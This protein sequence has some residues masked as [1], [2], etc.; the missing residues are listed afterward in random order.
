MK[1]CQEVKFRCLNRMCTY[2]MEQ[3]W[4]TIWLT[5]MYK[6]QKNGKSGLAMVINQQGILDWVGP[7]KKNGVKFVLPFWLPI[8]LWVMR[9]CETSISMRP[10]LL[11]LRPLP[12]YLWNNCMAI[13]KKINLSMLW[14]QDGQCLQAGP[15]LPFPHFIILKEHLYPVSQDSYKFSTWLTVIVMGQ[16]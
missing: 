2:N 11:S 14:Q 3:L 13:L 8:V 16:W 5:I 10:H 1:R 12:I 6:G 4:F 15:A 9:D 7:S